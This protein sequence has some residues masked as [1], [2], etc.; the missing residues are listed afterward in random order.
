M[1]DYELYYWSVPF[2]GQ[3]VRAVL[4]YAGKTWTEAGDEAISRLM[5]GP[6]SRM[7]VPFMGP[8]LLIDKKADFAIA[9]MPAIVLYLGETLELMPATPALRALTLKIVNDAN[10]VIDEITLDGGREMWTDKRWRDFTPRLEK[11]MSLWEETGRR[12][13][14]KAASGFLLGGAE[15]GIADVVTAVLWSTMTDRFPKIETILKEAAPKTAALTRRV[16][17]LPPLAA[18]AAK[19]QSDYGNAY[20]GGQI[21]ASLRKV[22]G[23]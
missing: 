19:A 22:L 17:G 12:H 11:W 20:C 16:A 21:E 9:Q 8:P 23:A 18:L 4:A 2:R 13:G 1:A 10:D 5:E 14:L 3:F 15:P 6:V 7:P